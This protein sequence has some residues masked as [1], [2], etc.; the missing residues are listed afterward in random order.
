[1]YEFLE[2]VVSDVMSKPTV[3]GSGATLAEMEQI[4]EQTGYNGLPVVQAGEL[5]GFVTS[6]DLLD[7]FRF[8]PDAILPPYDEI[9]RRPVSSVM[10]REPAI[11]QPTTRLTRVLEKMIATRNKSFPV[12][13]PKNERLVGVIAREDV[14]R[15]LRR[16]NA[17][18]S[19]QEE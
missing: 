5:V 10:V 7:A 12:V 9:M 16:A 19:Y 6:L 17:G 14:M 8:T 15:A 3:I 4:L 2:Y 18:R 11:V 13:D 1:M